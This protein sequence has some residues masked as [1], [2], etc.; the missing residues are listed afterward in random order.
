MGGG[1]HFTVKKTKEA[2]KERLESLL[3]DRLQKML[4]FGTTCVEVKSGYGL[5]V[6]TELKMLE[7]IHNVKK[8][9][10]QTITATYC[11]PHAVPRGKTPE[12]QTQHIIDDH[13]PALKKALEDKVI[14]MD[15]ID[16]FTETGVFSVEQTERIVEAARKIGLDQSLNIHVEELSQIGGA[17]MVA[18]LSNGRAASHLEEVSDEGIKQMALKNVAAVLLPTTALQLKLKPPPTRKMVDAGCIISLGSDFNPNAHCYNMPLVMYM[19]CTLYSMSMNEALAAATINSAYALERE[20]DLGSLEVGKRADFLV[21]D[22]PSWE[23][24]IYQVGSADTVI[25]S[26]F[27]NGEQCK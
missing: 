22:A 7:V 26:V 11:G 24:V 2:T 25:E 6:A 1:I 19:G 23:H 17:E 14:S 20:N 21:L 18:N 12:S 5:D 27:V 4:N 10:P 16:A 3:K 15:Q 8:Q 9:V 13:L